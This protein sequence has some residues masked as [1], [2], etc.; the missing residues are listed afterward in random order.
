MVIKMLEPVMSGRTD[1]GQCF[2]VSFFSQIPRNGIAQTATSSTKVWSKLSG[3]TVD[4]GFFF[5]FSCSIIDIEHYYK[6]EASQ[7]ALVVKNLPAHAGDR[8][9]WV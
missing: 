7:V 1:E 6:F 5:W 3:Q 8:R 9:D 4:H 2:S